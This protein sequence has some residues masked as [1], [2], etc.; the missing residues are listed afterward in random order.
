MI[1]EVRIDSFD[2]S[3]LFYVSQD[4]LPMLESP[5]EPILLHPNQ[6]TH[7]DHGFLF[8]ASINL[9]ANVSGAG[10]IFDADAPLGVIFSYNTQLSLA[11]VGDPSA[12][13]QWIR[14]NLANGR[15]AGTMWDFNAANPFA[16]RATL[17]GWTEHRVSIFTAAL[18]NLT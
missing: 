13:A 5:N 8:L 4:S 18:S 10:H 7:T 2:S 3:K 14:S 11:N 9:V 15:L 6:S 1:Y 12:T 17:S 16:T